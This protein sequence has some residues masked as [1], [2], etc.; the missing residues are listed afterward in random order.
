MAQ[1]S[2]AAVARRFAVALDTEDY[3]ALADLLADECQYEAAGTI[4]SGPRAIIASY[5]EAGS[6]VKSCIQS[7][8]YESIVRT[9]EE[10]Q[11]TVT[12]F[13]HF[14]HNERKHTYVCEQ[15]VYVDRRERVCR[16]V[17]RELPGQRESAD[18]FL[19][20]FGISRLRSSN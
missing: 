9:D 16:I 17:H 10:D 6:W 5:R 12:F 13:D 20:G 1:I 14:E 3:P 8:K 7:I 11:A 15:V 4:L 19:R 18:L 2:A